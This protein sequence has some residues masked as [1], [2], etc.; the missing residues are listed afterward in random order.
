MDEERAQCYHKYWIWHIC[1]ADLLSSWAFFLPLVLLFHFPV[2]APLYC[3][4]FCSSCHGTHGNLACRFQFD[5]TSWMPPQS[6]PCLDFCK[7][8]WIPE[9][10]SKSKKERKTVFKVTDLVTNPSP[11]L[12]MRRK[13]LSA[14]LCS[15]MNSSK[16]S[17]PSCADIIHHTVNYTVNYTS[18]SLHIMIF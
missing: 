13:S 15:P 18:Y 5:Q 9:I 7:L 12:S 3:K 11:S 16:E 10:D 6:D 1:D 8:L 14:R 4:F 2:L 17:R